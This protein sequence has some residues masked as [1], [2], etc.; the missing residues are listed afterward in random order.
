MVGPGR[1]LYET[2]DAIYVREKDDEDWQRKYAKFC[3]ESAIF[4]RQ[5]DGKTDE[6]ERVLLKLAEELGAI[7]EPMRNF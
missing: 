5:R 3:S 1:S 7:F 6:R 2:T 4:M